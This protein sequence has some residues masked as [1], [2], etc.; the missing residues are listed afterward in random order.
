MLQ[1]LG[2]SFVSGKETDPPIF[3]GGLGL[4]EDFSL[5]YVTCSVLTTFL[6]K[7]VSFFPLLDFFFS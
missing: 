7:L 4:G 3:P 6:G 2:E 1:F 5:A